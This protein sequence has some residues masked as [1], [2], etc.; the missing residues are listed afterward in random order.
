MIRRQFLA[1]L[2][3]LCAFYGIKPWEVDEF[4]LRELEEFLS[5]LPRR[6]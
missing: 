4:T 5:Q 1:E 2:P 3:A 6:D